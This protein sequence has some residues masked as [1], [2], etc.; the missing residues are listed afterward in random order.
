MI[1]TELAP[2]TK[3]LKLLIVE[4]EDLVRAATVQLFKR[5]FAVVDEAADGSEGLEKF[6]SKPKFYDLIITDIHMPNMDGIQM[7]EAIRRDDA[8]IPI[9]VLSAY[10]D[11]GNILNAI[12]TGADSFL[13]KPFTIKTSVD[14]FYR[15]TIRITDAKILQE[16]IE[17]IEEE[18]Y[19]LNQELTILRSKN[20]IM[21]SAYQATQSQPL[22]T[23]VNK[24][25][26]SQIAEPVVD[27]NSKL[28]EITPEKV[29][30][31]K[32]NNQAQ[33]T[34]IYDYMDPE[35]LDDIKENLTRLNSLLLIVGSGDITHDEVA[36]I[37]YYLQSIGRSASAYNESYSIS[38]ALGALASVIEA[39]NHTFIEK[40]SS[41]G[42]L[43]KSF[44]VDLVNWVQMIFHDGAISVD[45]MDDTII[46]NS[47]ML[48]SMLTINESVNEAVDMDDIFDF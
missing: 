31:K 46:S 36:E 14:S 26:I 19:F 3:N 9:V 20:S 35:D 4:D 11:F 41:L 40:S 43:C 45:V 13:P 30:V 7:I 18:N 16:H 1:F 39:N 33:Q 38:R 22:Q 37:S 32:F 2:Y 8:L 10:T 27:N 17:Q 23:A 48:G 5:V 21:Y 42:S 15:L 47:Q 29:S 25:Q 12:N 34:Y 44:G 24:V 6:K 28:L